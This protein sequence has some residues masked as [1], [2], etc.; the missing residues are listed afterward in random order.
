[1]PDQ[2][3]QVQAM[4]DLHVENALRTHA[5]RERAQGLTHCETLDCGE[6]IVPA[7]QALGARLC[8]DCQRAEEAA[9]AHHRVWRR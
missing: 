6:P 8:I 5:R 3:D 2:M 1:M 9:A 4:N 7:R